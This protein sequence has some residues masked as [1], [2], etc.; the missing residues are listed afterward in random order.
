MNSQF[1]ITLLIIQ[2]LHIQLNMT[3][4]KKP[5]TTIFLFTILISIT[6]FCCRNN[7]KAIKADI[8]KTKIYN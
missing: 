7:E 2:I 6:L 4:I 8:L 3:D 5:K 1:S